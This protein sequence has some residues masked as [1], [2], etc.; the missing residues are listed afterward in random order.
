[1]TKEYA[2]PGLRLGYIT[3]NQTLS[4]FLR[5]QRMP[6]TI[7]SISQAAAIYLLRH[8]ADYVLP[9]AD[10]LHERERVATELA[11]TGVIEPWPSDTHILLCR[12]RIGRASAL[13]EWLATERGILIRDAS[14]FEGLDA[15][16]F[17][18]AVQTPEE[19]NALIAAI[20]EWIK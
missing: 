17:R 3:T 8:K 2:V 20:Q 18:I 4:E 1:M 12:L 6:W 19:N 9:L 14:N 16:F 5:R 13:K 10:L 7:S 11:K 15:S